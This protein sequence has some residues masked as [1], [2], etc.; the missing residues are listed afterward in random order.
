MAN[1]TSILSDIVERLQATRLF[2]GLELSILEEFAEQAILRNYP[3]YT[4][5]CEPTQKAKHF[6]L[7]KSGWVKLYRDSLDGQEAVLD[8]L[9]SQQFFGETAHFSNNSYSWYAESIEEL[10]LIQF[11]STLL[12]KHIKQTP[13]LAINMIAAM[14]RHRAQQDGEIERFMLQNAPQRLGCFLLRLL[15]PEAAD[16]GA[17]CPPI[18]LP[19]NKSLL[20]TRLGMTPETFSRA[21]KTLQKN[22]DIKASGLT[23]MIG[24]FENLRNYTCRS[25]SNTFPC[26]D[27]T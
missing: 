10:E 17:P 19:Y 7:V 15:P 21:L 2:A 12:Q 27:L 25:C 14:S 1:R 5:L 16:K 4:L 3:K 9:N 13:Q 23:I 18:Q 11:P 6:F 26:D 24:N 8:V 20:A 22:T